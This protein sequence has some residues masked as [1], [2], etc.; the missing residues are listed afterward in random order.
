MA[1]DDKTTELD[2]TAPGGFGVR[3]K[4][5]RLMDLVCVLSAFG[6]GYLTM[7]AYTHAADSRDAKETVANTLKTSNDSI[8]KALSESNAAT[9]KAIEG[10]AIEQKRTTRV[11]QEISCLNDPAMKN[12]S[13][14]RDSCK[15][16]IRDN[17]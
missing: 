15:R 11:L 8:A 13:D 10:F 7:M 6:I 17:Q 16:I 12:R 4:N 1:D 5:Y 2:I 3:T 14:A 9:A